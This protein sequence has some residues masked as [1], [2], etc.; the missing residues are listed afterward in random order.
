MPCTYGRN[1]VKLLL[2]FQSNCQSMCRVGLASKLIKT[3]V[4]VTD[5]NLSTAMKQAVRAFTFCCKHVQ[6]KVACFV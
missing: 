2:G 1:I 6:F 5:K 3:N 4:W